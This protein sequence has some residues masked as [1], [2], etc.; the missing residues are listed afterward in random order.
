MGGQ[1]TS[2]ARP[3][4]SSKSRCYVRIERQNVPDF[5][6]ETSKGVIS[7]HEFIGD[8]LVLALFPSGGLHPGVHHR[9]SGATAKLQP[10]W[11]K[12]GVKVLRPQAC[13]QRRG[14]R[15]QSD[16]RHQRNPRRRPLDFPIIAERKDLARCRC[17]SAC[18][19]L[20]HFR[21][22]ASSSA[23]PRPC[24]TCTSISPSEAGRTHR[25]VV[26]SICRPQLR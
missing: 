24:A 18:S 5:I 4:S 26:P 7:F 10:E 1:R 2:S 15:A 13:R 11:A 25:P 21:H 14:S 6:A 16:R 23:R 22:G 19:T 3:K 8:L 20:T 17:S 12:R 9:T